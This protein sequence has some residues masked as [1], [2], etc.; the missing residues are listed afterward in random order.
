MPPSASFTTSSGLLISFC[1]SLLSV[2]IVQGHT[3][4]RTA[5]ARAHPTP[6]N[7]PCPYHTTNQPT[8]AVSCL[9]SRLRAVFNRRLRD[10]AEFCAAYHPRTGHEVVDN[11]AKN[12]A[13]DRSYEIHYEVSKVVCATEDHLKYS[14]SQGTEG[15]KRY[16]GDGAKGKDVR[17]NRQGDDQ[18]RPT[19]RCAT[20][21]GGSHNHQQQEEGTNGLCSGCHQ[22][23][24]VCI[25]KVCRTVAN[26]CCV[27]KTI[28]YADKECTYKCT[29]KLS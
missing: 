8:R 27:G 14:W 5:S 1:N 17:C 23:S 21:D 16:V 24:C 29:E 3:V 15:V 2:A 19:G 12:T 10:T 9:L 20:I 6:P 25:A 4:P 28:A 7:H 13:N 18:T 11:D 26:R 22:V